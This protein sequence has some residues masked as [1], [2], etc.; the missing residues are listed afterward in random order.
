MFLGQNQQLCRG[1]SPASPNRDGGGSSQ[2]MEAYRCPIEFQKARDSDQ[3]TMNAGYL[4]RKNQKYRKKDDGIKRLVT[5]LIG[6]PHLSM[7]DFL[8]GVTISK[9]TR[10]II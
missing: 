8:R 7:M 3:L 1:S 4:P 10:K 6:N 2:H 9:W 5:R